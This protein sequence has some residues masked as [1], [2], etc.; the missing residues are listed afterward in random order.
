MEDGASGSGLQP[1]VGGKNGARAY[2]AARSELRAH[3]RA[4]REAERAIMAQEKAAEKAAKKLKAS[5][6]KA[7][8]ARRSELH[9]QGLVTDREVEYITK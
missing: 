5:Q 8:R 9:K 7:E 2:N 1:P 6:N 3:N 4:T